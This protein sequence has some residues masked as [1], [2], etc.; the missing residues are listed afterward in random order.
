M[1]S[2]TKLNPETGELIVEAVIEA[3]TNALTQA[4]EDLG[5]TREKFYL[6]LQGD[7]DNYADSPV[8]TLN[9]DETKRVNLHLSKLTTGS[10]AMV[11][12]YCGGD[13]CPFSNRCPLFAVSKHPEGKQCH[14]PGTLIQ[15]PKGEVPIEKLTT[16]DR[17]LTYDTQHGLIRKRGRPFTISTRDYDGYLVEVT[18]DRGGY[19]CTHDHICM[20]TW[21]KKA[22][23]SFCVY[24]MQRGQDFRIGKTSLLKK[25]GS[26]QYSGL[27]ARTNREKADK[28]WILG[29]YDTNTEASL[30]EERFSVKWQIP[31]AC[32]LS[33]EYK[34]KSKDNGLYKW[35]T[36]DQLDTHHCSLRQK[37]E[38]YATCLASINLSINFPFWERHD[39]D[40]SEFQPIGSV[41]KLFQVR[42]CNLVSG[43]MSMGA[44]DRQAYDQSLGLGNVVENRLRHKCMILVKNIPYQGTVYALDVEKEH[45][46]IAGNL[47]THN[48]PIENRLIKEFI[49]RYMEEYDINPA[50]W[51]EVRYAAELA[52][53]DIYLMRI[54]MVLAR[55]EHADMMIEQLTGFS[56]KGAPIVQTQL[57]PI[58]EQKE[59]LEGRRSRIIKFMVG[60]RQEKYKKQAA[61]KEV[62]EDNIANK[63][64]EARR[65]IDKLIS[66]VGKTI[67]DSGTVEEKLSPEDLFNSSDDV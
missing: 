49:Y 42:A 20:A 54:H 60:D 25:T 57:H 48:C 28:I 31:K 40:S 19:L 4:P 8:A 5:V 66:H 58:L 16:Q 13:K 11:P 61:L 44:F 2:N 55:P 32:F 38:H 34:E 23:G 15:T 18:S 41:G 50:I 9:E 47:I 22:L 39:H 6:S 7:L 65:A 24:L 35:V 29:I 27:S 30:A 52:E 62:Q 56:V 53:I 63:M 14:P 67:K 26:R 12:L 1:G 59:R 21:N 43:Y 46:Y 51:T 17:V 33:S 36:Q 64:V 37:L 10:S 45:T 3:K